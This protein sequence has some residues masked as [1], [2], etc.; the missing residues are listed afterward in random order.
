MAEPTSSLSTFDLVLDVALTAKVAYYGNTGQ[1]AAAIPINNHD[2]QKCLRCVNRG[3]NLFIAS[4]PENGWRWM[5]RIMEVTLGTVQT[6]G[7]VDSGDSTSLIDA[8][9][10]DTY[11]TDDEIVGYYVY[12]QTKEIYAAITAYTAATGD[13]TVTEWLD[14]D[15][16]VSSSTPAANDSYSITD[17]KTIDGDKARYPLS[18][19]FQGEVSGKITYA[20]DSGRGHI[21]EWCH[22]AM[23]RTKREVNVV[24]GYVTRAATRPWRKRRWE[25][26]VDPSP[27]AGDTLIFPYRVGFDKL[28]IEAGDASAAGTTSITDS[29]LAN[30][31]PDDYFNGWYAYIMAGTGRGS[32]AKV[33]DYTGNTGA[34][35]VADWLKCTG[36]AGGIDPVANSG[37]YVE[38]ADNKHPAGHQFDDAVRAACLAMAEREFDDINAGY[39][40]EFLERALPNAYKIDAR[41]APRKLGV[42]LPGTRPYYHKRNWENITLGT[43]TGGVFTED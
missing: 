30:L 6:E 17:V 1:E 20:A 14:Y 4:A 22:E 32:Y 26:I 40:G 18:Q 21:V 34:F 2:L 12:D 43:V 33:T 37:F 23:V 29:A 31:Y 13:I 42:M 10:T 8:T 7:T 39:M 3:I 28:E 11:D 27:T 38:P 35:T 9:L 19:D 36:A 15:D 25:L 41:S 5:N 16:I 24:T